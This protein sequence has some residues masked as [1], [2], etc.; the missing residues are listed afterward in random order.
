M[1]FLFD[2]AA[3][4]SGAVAAGLGVVIFLVLAVVAFIAFRIFRKSLKLAFRLAI[5]AAILFLAFAGSLG[6]WLFAPGKP[7]PRPGPQRNK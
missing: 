7:G 1:I 5:L 2:I 3:P 6:Y 4:A